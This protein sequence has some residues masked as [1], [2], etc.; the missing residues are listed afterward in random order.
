MLQ[1]R[2]FAGTLPR[3]VAGSV[4]GQA[5]ESHRTF[6]SGPSAPT[7]RPTLVVVVLSVTGMQVMATIRGSASGPTVLSDAFRDGH[8]RA[9]DLRELIAEAWLWDDS[10]TSQVPE[11]DWLSMFRAVNF[12]T[13]PTPVP[14]PNQSVTLYRACTED[15]ARRMSW[16]GNKALALQFGNRH[17]RYGVAHLYQSRVS[18][19]HVLAYLCRNDEGW[20]VVVDPTGLS[21]VALDGCGLNSCAD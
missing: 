7:L 20:T 10:P 19:A 14:A 6:W 1:R 16:T 11:S 4:G 18:Q 15:R 2:C 9:S 8:L 3:C 13:Y 5:G 17:Q 12:F 21:P